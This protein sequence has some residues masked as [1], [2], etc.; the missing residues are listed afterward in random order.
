MLAP[1][2]VFAFNRADVLGDTLQAL[3]ANEMA[4]DSQIFIFVDGP[5]SEQDVF[6][7]EAVKNIVEKPWPFKSVERRYA[8]KNKGLARSIIE[9]TTE[10]IN[11]FGRVIVVEDD[12]HVSKGFL[13]FMNTMLDKYEHDERIFQVSGFGVKLANVKDYP[14][15]HYMHLRAHS[16]T[17]GT[18]KDRWKTVDWNVADFPDFCK[19]KQK[20]RAFNKGGS[21][22][23]GML[24]GFFAHKNNS[25][26]IRFTYA[27]FCQGRYAVMPVRSL[28]INNGFQPGATHC[29][30]YNRYKVD[31]DSE[32]KQEWNIPEHLEFDSH[33]GREA[34]KYWSIRYR[35]Y[36][37]LMTWLAKLH[38]Q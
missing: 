2:I 16:W 20:Q 27:M 5:R 21:D 12:L 29:N 34:S 9:G 35:I 8:K 14:Y 22:L 17:W 24:K 25:W 26:Y 36:G 31:F 6:K 37:K 19:D 3:A 23:T 28:V 33:I 32:G 11:R 10:I 30:T 4:S 15:D 38:Q 1:I 18:W 13:R 7:I